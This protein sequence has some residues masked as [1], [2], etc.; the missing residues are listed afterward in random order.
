MALHERAQARPERRPRTGRGQIINASVVV[1]F[2]TL[3]TAVVTYWGKLF[4]PAPPRGEVTGPVHADSVPRAPVVIVRVDT[5]AEIQ[6]PSGLTASALVDSATRDTLLLA[7][8]DEQSAVYAMRAPDTAAAPAGQRFPLPVEA[9]DLED[10]TWDGRFRYYAI[11]SHRTRDTTPTREHQRR[12]IR[13]AFPAN[14]RAPGAALT[15]EA[16]DLAPALGQFLDGVGVRVDPAWATKTGDRE[17]PYA[18]EIEGLAY[19]DGVLLL[20]LKWPLVH[21]KAVLLTYAPDEQRFTAWDTLDLG[22]QGITALAFLAPDRLAVASNPPQQPRNRADRSDPA[23]GRSMIRVFDVAPGATRV[24]REVGRREVPS[25]GAK[26]EGLAAMGDAVVLAY[27]G[28]EA[29]VR[30]L[31]KPAV[32]TLLGRVR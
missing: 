22:G 26:L 6:E 15:G 25:V 16:W 10:I 20:G 32:D 18:L 7:V 28:V 12:L 5:V 4:P 13:F 17:H 3:L 19:R 2:L 31:T 11:T 24:G 21:Q 29:R 9:K 23:Y 8:D 1:A 30:R 14:P 27:D